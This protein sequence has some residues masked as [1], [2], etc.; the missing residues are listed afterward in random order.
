MS[1]NIL[2]KHAP[3]LFDYHAMKVE[4]LPTLTFTN[5]A[6]Y[7]STALNTDE[8]AFRHSY[9]AA[10]E[11][12]NIKR[13]ASLPCGLI[14]GN[15]TALGV[16]ATSDHHTISSQLM[17]RTGL[18]WWNLGA[19][20]YSSTQ[21]LLSFH[22]FRHLF[23]NLK[24]VVMFSGV[25]DP[26]LYFQS[27][28]FPKYVGGAYYWTHLLRGVITEVSFTSRIKR[29]LLRGICQ[30]DVVWPQ[31]SFYDALRRRITKNSI[32]MPRLPVPSVAIEKIKN[33]NSQKDTLLH[34]LENNFRTWG[35]LA[36]YE[37]FRLIYVLQP[38]ATWIERTPTEKEQELF[39]FVYN[40]GP[41]Q[42]IHVDSMTVD[43]YKWYAEALKSMC[44]KYDVEFHDMNMLLA[45]NKDKD[46]WLFVDRVHL[47]DRGY[48]LA[49][50]IIAN[51]IM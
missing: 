34:A 25:I 24:T 5:A 9:T 11:L 16:G 42:R 36:K 20:G 7:Q 30:S 49:A 21:E 19:R 43:F 8:Y 38:L 3:Q 13:D 28:N 39:E 4:W 31:V 17:K 32:G 27:M 12:V 37:K 6:R 18:T 1:Q 46:E 33:H 26:V 40:K 41:S 15:S 44:E 14:V 35:A 22:T 51:K 48:E 10:G 2:I 23:S 50:E 29:R 45:D 47:T